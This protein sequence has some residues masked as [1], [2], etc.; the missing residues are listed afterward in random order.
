MTS[1]MHHLSSETRT[2]LPATV[3]V[4]NDALSSYVSVFMCTSEMSVLAYLGLMIFT[5]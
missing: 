4:L 2:G 3:H 5:M 1:N